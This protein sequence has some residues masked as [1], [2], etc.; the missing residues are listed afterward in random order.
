MAPS[1]NKP[2][3]P[4]LEDDLKPVDIKDFISTSRHQHAGLAKRK[5]EQDFES[6]DDK[7]IPCRIAKKR[8]S[9]NSPAST[10]TRV[11]RSQSGAQRAVAPEQTTSQMTARNSGGTDVGKAL[12]YQNALLIKRCD[13]LEAVVADLQ[14]K[15]DASHLN[16]VVLLTTILE[17]VTQAAEDIDVMRGERDW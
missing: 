1:T 16:L 15:A 12:K 8:S 2:I 3:L 4:K 5:R 17:K 10:T 13:A 9:D 6:D 11:L 14:R 7:D